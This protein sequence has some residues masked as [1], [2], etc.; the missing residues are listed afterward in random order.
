MQLALLA[1]GAVVARQG[2]TVVTVSAVSNRKDL[3]DGGFLPLSVEY[4]V[5]VSH[6]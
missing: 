5:K 4:R 1:D 6:V 2:D 3:D